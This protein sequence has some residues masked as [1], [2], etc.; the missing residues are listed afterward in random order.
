MACSGVLNAD[1]SPQKSQQ[2]STAFQC[3]S[4]SRS[5]N[6]TKTL[7]HFCGRKICYVLLTGK[8]AEPSPVRTELR[9]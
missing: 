5:N 3:D 7:P 9:I 2:V 6:Q 4:L 8:V 1:I